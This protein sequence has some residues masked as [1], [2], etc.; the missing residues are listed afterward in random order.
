MPFMSP[1]EKE[2]IDCISIILAIKW[3]IM[4]ISISP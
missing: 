4:V 3:G 1:V 2:D